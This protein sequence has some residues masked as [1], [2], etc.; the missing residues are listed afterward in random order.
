MSPNNP[1]ALPKIST[2]NILTNN[3]ELAASARAAPDPTMP[4]AIPQN[5]F[6]N[7]TATPAPNIKYP[8]IQ[9]FALMLMSFS[10]TFQVKFCK[11]KVSSNKVILVIRDQPTSKYPESTIA[12]MRPYIATASQKI[13]EI[14]F[15]VFILGAFTPPPIILTPVV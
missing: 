5:K 6:T 15:L 10:T 14:R 11:L 13:T 1:M 9:F 2:I 3:A 8:A 7:P 4:T 12:V